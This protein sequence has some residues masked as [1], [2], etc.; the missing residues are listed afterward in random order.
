M[1]H[2]FALLAADDDDEDDDGMSEATTKSRSRRWAQRWIRSNDREEAVAQDEKGSRI[3]I[4]A[5]GMC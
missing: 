2:H 3:I 5:G 1:L 4:P